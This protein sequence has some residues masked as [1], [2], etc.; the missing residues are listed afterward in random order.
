MESDTSAQPTITEVLAEHGVHVTAE[1]KAR[2][3]ERL[4]AADATRDHAGRA[5]FR[6]RLR[7]RP[8]SAA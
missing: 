2:A 4:R 5:A 1:G 6:A 3:G 7:Q 8:A